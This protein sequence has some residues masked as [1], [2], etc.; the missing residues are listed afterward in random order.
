MHQV[1]FS[2]M[3]ELVQ[4]VK[5][6]RK[7]SVKKLV[8]KRLAEFK[9][10]GKKQ[11][12]ELFKEL[13]FCTLTANFDAAKS[14][15]IQE[16][17]CNGF[18]ELPEKELEKKLRALGY[19][20]PNRA[21]YICDSRKHLVGLKKRINSSKSEFEL[22]EWLAKNVK[23]LGFKEASHFLRNVGFENLAIVD[24][25]I[26]DLL[27]RHRLIKRPK[28]MSRKRYLEIEKVLKKI[29]SKLEMPLAELD[30]YLWFL[31]TGKVLK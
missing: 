14:M 8:D 12:K 13:C 29:A 25:H 31:E 2:A 17:V 6:L 11:G 1:R 5:K 18:S 24:F 10:L 9:E 21:S 30:L 3:K 27:A 26:V 22:R 20:Y 7:G 4:S 23:G 16:K 19:R 15:V 28:T